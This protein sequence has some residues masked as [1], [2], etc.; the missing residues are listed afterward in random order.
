MLSD[1]RPKKKFFASIKSI[2]ILLAC[3]IWHVILLLLL[4]CM[5][6]T[7]TLDLTVIHWNFCQYSWQ[8]RIWKKE[9]S[10]NWKFE[11]CKMRKQAY[12]SCYCMAFRLRRFICLALKDVTYI[13]NN[14]GKKKFKL[15]IYR[16]AVCVAPCHIL[17][18]FRRS[19]GFGTKNR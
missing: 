12:Y 13:Q 1:E 15:F 16:L 4:R 11:T 10:K 9:K 6:Y 5:I 3:N 14:S 18:R 17:Y 2:K 7:Y 19:G 8:V